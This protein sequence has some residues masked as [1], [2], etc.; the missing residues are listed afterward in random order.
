MMPC[1]LVDDGQEAGPVLVQQCMLT[2][3]G[4]ARGCMAR[5]PAAMLLHNA[6]GVY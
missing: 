5:V 4:E 1:M 3:A 6:G 2:L